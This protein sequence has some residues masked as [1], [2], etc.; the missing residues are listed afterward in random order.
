MTA[1][2]VEAYLLL[3]S[4]GIESHLLGEILNLGRMANVDKD[5]LSSIIR[6]LQCKAWFNIDHLLPL[7]ESMWHVILPPLAW[8]SIP[9]L[10]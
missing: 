2:F 1:T 3:L 10:T 7:S 8:R 5:F 4:F 9:H 6:R